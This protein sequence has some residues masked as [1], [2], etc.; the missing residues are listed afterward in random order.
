MSYTIK[1]H[2]K[3]SLFGPGSA[4]IDLN[5]KVIYYDDLAIGLNAEVIDVLVL[6]YL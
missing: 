1:I 6:I 5:A 2:I 3:Y 4:V